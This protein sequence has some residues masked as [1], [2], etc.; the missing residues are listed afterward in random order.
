LATIRNEFE[1][2]DPTVSLHFPAPRKTRNAFYGVSI[3]I[4]AA[5]D[6]AKTSHAGSEKFGQIQRDRQTHN[7]KLDRVLNG[8]SLLVYTS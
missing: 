1:S 4:E 6:A 8:P 3:L 2:P 7:W 5:R